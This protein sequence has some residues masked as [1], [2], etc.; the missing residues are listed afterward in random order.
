MVLISRH[1]GRQSNHQL[2]SGVAE[3]AIM[4][5]REHYADFGHSLA[6]EKLA[7][8]HGLHFDYYTLHPRK[9]S[10]PFIKPRHGLF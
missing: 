10:R 2:A 1:R 7:E 8:R 4:I 3:Q 6:C 5:I 9:H